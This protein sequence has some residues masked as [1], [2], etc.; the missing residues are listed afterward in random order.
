MMKARESKMLDKV[1]RWRRKA[2]EADKAASSLKQAK[3]DEQMVQK[4]G[5]S[6][7]QTPKVG[8]ARQQ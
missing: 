1:R 7:L 5:L 2:Y 4:L 6:V 3:A 8:S